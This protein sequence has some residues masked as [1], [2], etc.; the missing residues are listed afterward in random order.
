MEN[1]YHFELTLWNK[2][3]RFESILSPNYHDALEFVYCNDS[4][5]VGTT[6]RALKLWGG[7]CL[8]NPASLFNPHI[9]DVP[10]L[11]QF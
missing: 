6:L 4:R 8:V 9:Y 10:N 5:V 11:T 7:L 1:T 2:T 3:T